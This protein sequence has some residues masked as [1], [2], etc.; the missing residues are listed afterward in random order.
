MPSEE[1]IRVGAEALVM[2]DY[3]T[4]EHYHESPGAEDFILY[5]KSARTALEAAEIVREK[6]KAIDQ[7][8]AGDYEVMDLEDDDRFAGELSPSDRY[9]E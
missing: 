5:E 1:E 8:M 4:M 7:V 6:E 3:V 2:D 9:R